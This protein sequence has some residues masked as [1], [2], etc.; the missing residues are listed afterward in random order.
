[1]WLSNTLQCLIC[2]S[3]FGLRVNK[4]NVRAV[5][6]YSFPSSL[7]AYMQETERGGRDGLLAQCILFFNPKN[8]IF[9]LNNLSSMR[10]YNSLNADRKQLSFLNMLHWC[11]QVL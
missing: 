4:P 11:F 3:S 10:K 8:Q 1:M 2:T 9:Q 6:H 7:E 5:V